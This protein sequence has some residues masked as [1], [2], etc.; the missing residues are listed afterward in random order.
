[1]SRSESGQVVASIAGVLASYA[2]AFWLIASPHHHLSILDRLGYLSAIYCVLGVGVFFWAKILAVV[3]KVRLWSRRDCQYAPILTIIPG[4]V[5]FLAGGDALSVLN[6]LL[7]EAMFIRFRL[8][9]LA[10]PNA[11]DDSPFERENP[12]TMFPQ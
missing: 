9:K 1:M 3:A 5:L 4:C 11:S 12:A 10:F 2:A 8:S 6:F 7:F